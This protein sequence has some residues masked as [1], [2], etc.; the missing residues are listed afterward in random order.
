MPVFFNHRTKK[1]LT[2]LQ[3]VWERARNKAQLPWLH[4]H[5]LRHLFASRMASEVNADLGSLA[6][7]LGHRDIKQ[8]MR[9]RNLMTHQYSGMVEAMAQKVFGK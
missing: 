3:H 7:L 1:Q 9:Y 6:D 4:I 8:T 5:D 2:T